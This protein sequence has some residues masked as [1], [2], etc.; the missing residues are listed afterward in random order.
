MNEGEILVNKYE[1]PEANL[2]NPYGE[3]AKKNAEKVVIEKQSLKD[4]LKKL[5][6]VKIGQKANVSSISVKGKVNNVLEEDPDLNLNLS[7][8]E[9]KEHEKLDKELEVSNALK[10]KIE[11]EEAKQKY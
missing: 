7:E 4:K 3:M 10:A 6:E 5:K 1:L 8:K 2:R 9:L 11:V